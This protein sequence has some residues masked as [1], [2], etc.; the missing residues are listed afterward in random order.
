MNK[1]KKEDKEKIG[2]GD[3]QEEMHREKERVT[4][5]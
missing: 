4:Q 5:K 1:C 3:V 2:E